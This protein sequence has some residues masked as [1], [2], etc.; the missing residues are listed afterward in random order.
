MRFRESSAEGEIYSTNT[1]ITKKESPRIYKIILEEKVGRI[2]LPDI[3][4]YY[5]APQL[6]GQCGTGGSIDTYH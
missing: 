3:K 5:L 1:Y 2:V 6:S 4:A